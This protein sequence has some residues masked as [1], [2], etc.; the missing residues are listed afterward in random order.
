MEKNEIKENICRCKLFADLGEKPIGRLSDNASVLKIAKDDRVPQMNGISLI[1]SGKCGVYSLQDDKKR[2][3]NILAATDCFGFA[4]MY[5]ECDR[6]STEI[7]AK[8]NA[9]I[10]FLPTQ[11]IEE[12][13]Q[14]DG[15][16]G[17]KIIKLLSGK[18]RFLNARIYSY[19]SPSVQ[20]RVMKYLRECNVD[21][22]GYVIIEEKMTSV[23]DRLGIGRAS[24]YRVLSSLEES[25]SI[26]R[27]KDRIKTVK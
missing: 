18:I 2:L 17:L 5:T 16:F 25:G 24:L 20:D 1:A 19:L 26:V 13:V 7:I 21:E 6:H 12:T 9:E 10:I 14:E 11:V 22:E 23:A 3:L 8:S 4:S 15:R 27:D